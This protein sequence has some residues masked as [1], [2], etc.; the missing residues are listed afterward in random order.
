MATPGLA[1]PEASKLKAEPARMP[2]LKPHP[3]GGTHALPNF[4]SSAGNMAIQR[5]VAGPMSSHSA[6]ILGGAAMS[7]G[8][9]SCGGTC[10]EC[11]TPIQT[12]LTVGSVDDPLER[13]ADNVAEHV[14]RMP[15]RAAQDG[16]TASDMSPEG[17]AVQRKSPARPQIAAG[18]SAAPVATY[19][20]PIV[21]DVLRSPGQPLD[22]GAR[23]F[24]EPRFGRDF[25]GVRV[26]T[27]AKAARSAQAVDAL[28]YTAGRHIVFDIGQYAPESH[29]G[30]TL[31]AHEL[32]HTV[33]QS[34][35]TATTTTNV[36]FGNDLASSPEGPPLADAGPVAR[37]QRQRR[38][39][40]AGCG[41]CMNDPR[42]QAAGDIAHLEVQEAFRAQ[43]PDIIPE[44]EV[45]GIPG[46]GIDLS[47]ERQVA[48]QGVLFIGEIKPLDD[49][50]QQA[51][52]GRDQLRDYAREASLSG[53]WDEVFRMPDSPPPGPLYF[54]NP[55]RP[56]SCPP[57][58]IEVQ[59]TEP[60]LYQYYCEPPW[61]QLVRDPDCS[62]EPCRDE[63]D[64][65]CKE[66]EPE[67]DKEPGE[68]DTVP[69]Q[70]EK[71][72]GKLAEALAIDGL[73]DLGLGLVSALA[74]ALAPLVALAALVLAIVYFWD[75]LK[76]ILGKIASAAR[77][78]LGKFASFAQWVWGNFTSLLGLIAKLG[79]K[80]AELLSWL[81]DKIAWVIERVAEGIEWLA[82][83]LGE[84]AKW[85][86]HQIASG[87]RSVWDWLFGSDVEAEPPVIDL[88]ATE[89]PTT[90]CGTVA[91]EDALVRI[92]S[93][94]LFDTAH[95][96]L[97]PGA[98]ASLQG[99]AVKVTSMLRSSDDRVRVEGYTDNVGGVEYN[100]HLSEQRAATVAHWLIQNGAVQMS[101]IETEGFGKSQAEGKDE[102]GRARDRHVEIWINRHGSTEKVCW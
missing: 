1:P 42:G 53:E 52:L 82:D 71:L 29:A 81:G 25:S 65:D 61:S 23:S 14:M 76:S 57:Q 102:A 77:W 101:N 33:Q 74:V 87:A 41:I 96:D 10:D 85:L 80:L 46:S 62:C 17:P 36:E 99:A 34:K 67:K 92:P 58:L 16:P 64:P 9:C 95:W 30:R 15:D 18:S 35:S 45:P 88:P 11:K 68:G 91:H 73:L 12:K 39:A 48:S 78:A 7:G 22:A 19:A 26:H 40:A 28:A 75:T 79:I 98:E 49:A 54:Y 43:I 8:G 63:D 70:L 69:E 44:R 31:L 66:Q 6:A 4:L 94:L 50:R 47:Y 13:E 55:M 84:G 37:I 27:D 21:H 59:Q 20:P 24:M 32:S 5:A 60:G 38:G 51:G 100:Q 90:R 97:K 83:Q 72:G 89:E 86:G 56:P 2:A 93:D 3:P